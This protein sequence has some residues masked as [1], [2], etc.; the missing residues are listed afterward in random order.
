MWN[1]VTQRSPDYK[2]ARRFQRVRIGLYGSYMLP[3]GHELTCRIIDMS[4]GGMAIEGLEKG[5]PGQ[6]VIVYADV[7]GRLE[8]E[9]VR[10]LTDGLAIGISASRQKQEKLAHQ[11]TWLAN[12]HL[13]ETGHQDRD[14]RMVPNDARSAL[15]LPNGAFLPCRIVGMSSFGAIIAAP[16]SP[17][18]GMLVVVGQIRSRVVQHVDACFMVEFTQPRAAHTLQASIACPPDI[19]TPTLLRW[20]PKPSVS[21]LIQ[22]LRPP[23]IRAPGLETLA[24]GA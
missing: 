11:L 5:F 9:I 13:F 17:P 6:R 14:P 4:P 21:P 22:T 12:R 19:T 23:A 24:V 20:Q 10:G 16:K 2:D 18:V 1:S 7:L 8:G 3:N 15:F